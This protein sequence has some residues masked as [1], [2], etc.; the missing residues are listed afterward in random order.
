MAG[1]NGS[2]VFSRTYNWV[3]DKNNGIKIRA[4]R[5]DANDNDF[6]NGINNV[7]AKDGQNAPTANLPM[8]GYKHTNVT[9]ATAA[10]EYATLGQLQKNSGTYYDTT[11]SANAYI[12]TP[13]PAITSYAAGQR[14]FIKANFTNTGAATININSLGATALTKQGTN[15]LVSGDM[16]SGVIYEIIRDGTQFQV[17]EVTSTIILNNLRAATSGGLSIQNNSGTTVATFANDIL[18]LNS[19]GTT[20]GGQLNLSAGSSGGVTFSLDNFYNTS[21]NEVRLFCN[22]ALNTKVRIENFGA[23]TADVVVADSLSIGDTI[24]AAAG[25][26]YLDVNNLE[27]TNNSS[28][29]GLRL[30]T[31]NNANSATAA[32][33]MT[34]YK[35]GAVTFLNEE[36]NVTA[37]YSF[38]LS[39]F[40]L[41]GFTTV[42]TFTLS[43]FGASQTGYI[44]TSNASTNNDFTCYQDF[45]GRDSANNSE[46]YISLKPFIRDNTSGSEDST[47]QINVK[48]AGALV[49]ALEVGA[50]PTGV[51]FLSIFNQEMLALTS[52]NGYISIPVSGGTISRV[53]FQWGNQTVS[54]GAAVTFNLPVTYGTAQLCGGAT[55]QTVSAGDLDGNAV[56]F[57]PISTSQATLQSSD[58]SS[59]VVYWW[60]IGY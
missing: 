59:R 27:T 24:T 51:N 23:G 39:G 7:I 43:R 3:Q 41:S 48:K 36:T 32:L 21:V 12:L 28:A 2:G 55:S 47:Y 49:N 11:G 6:V 38:A 30:I 45:Y 34:K 54:A 19:S 1:W 25:I 56:G 13:N 50:S 58:S 5:H 52:A 33:Y 16:V 42:D 15:A 26:R 18:T 31:R 20:E 10:N 17:K 29:A 9:D 60:S 4:D 44:Y 35:N 53:I 22:S 46:L 14:F 40:S 37:Y 57:N 8:A